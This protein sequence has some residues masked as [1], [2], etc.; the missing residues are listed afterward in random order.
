LRQYPDL[1]LILV[2]KLNKSARLNQDYFEKHNF[3]NILFTDF[4]EDEQLNWLYA[5]AAVY[6]FPSLMEGF[7]LPP[8]EAML[9]GTP[10]VSS[11]ATCLPE[12]QGDAAYYFDPLDVS[13]MARAIDDVLKNEQ[14]RLD[15]IK[16]GYKQVKKY[17]WKKMAEQ[18]H[19]VYEDA[20][21]S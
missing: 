3:K 20:L 2:G 14:L 21:K 4:V 7:G 12:I 8:L 10:V 17:S 13:D 11:N 19:K 6:V 15:L 1:G 5:H 16:E 9:H 18:T